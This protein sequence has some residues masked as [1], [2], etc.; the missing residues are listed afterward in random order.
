MEGL[1][2]RIQYV[3]N[4]PKKEMSNNDDERQNIVQL[5]LQERKLPQ[6]Y[7]K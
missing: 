6:K 5:D 4:I 7:S 3:S 1:K 2:I